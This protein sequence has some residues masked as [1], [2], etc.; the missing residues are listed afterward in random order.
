[1]IKDIVIA[2]LFFVV[3]V[4]VLGL[5]VFKGYIYYIPIF[6]FSF[7]LGLIGSKF[8]WRK[9]FIYLILFVLLINLGV[10]NRTAYYIKYLHGKEFTDWI[11][12]IFISNIKV[13]AVILMSA[14]CARV[15]KNRRS[16]VVG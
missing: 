8:D 9:N 16:G 10:L 4:I 3:T 14:Y 5:D 15:Y 7:I 13:V 11:I 2:L 12:D 6:I 1:M